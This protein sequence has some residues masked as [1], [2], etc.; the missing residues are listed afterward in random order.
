MTHP[1]Y[2]T[3][4]GYIENQLPES[5][6]VKLEE[7]FSHSCKQ[8]SEKITLL[9]IALKAAAQDQ[10]VAPPVDV[11]RR[12][13]ALYRKRPVNP[14]QPLLRVFAEL[15]FDSRLQLSLSSVRGPGAAHTRQMLYSTQHVDIDLQITSEHGDNNLI[16]QILVSEK[17]TEKPAAFVSLHNKSGE[18]LNGTETDALGQFSFNQISAGVYDLDFDLGSQEVAIAGL[19]LG[20]D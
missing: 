17:S 14:L 1:T 11:L 13:V 8:C 5:E 3:L 2:M 10:T 19:E 12:A 16:G 18:L 9:R 6:R 15:Q 20:N 4:I 7:H